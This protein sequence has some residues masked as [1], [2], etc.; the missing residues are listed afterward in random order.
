M[1]NLYLEVARREWN[2]ARRKA[3]WLQL[4]SSLSSK[5]IDLINFD[6]LS[7]H[8]DLGNAAYRGV[9]NIPVAKIMGSVGRYQDFVQAFL[10]TTEN[11]RHRWEKIATLYLDPSSRGLPPIEVYQVGDGYF[12]ADGNHR[13]SVVRQLGLQDIEAHVWEYPQSVAGLA[14]GVD[15]DTLLIEAERRE[16]LAKTH[17]DELRPGHNIR[18]TAPGGYPEMLNQIAHYQQVLS[19]IDET[20]ISYEQAVRA[21]YDMIYKSTVLLI[22]NAGVLDIFPN[23]TAADFFIWAGQH[24][25]ELEEQYGQAVLMEDAVKD[26]RKL[27]RTPVVI[28]SWRSVWGWLKHRL[29]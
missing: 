23:R 21:W 16:F 28:R 11:M 7:Q 15:I 10:P 18:L 9:Q 24:H 22:E 6:Q 4:R 1:E 26:I 19:L 17:L 20:E 12:V 5:K 8:F 2:Q 27:N 25:R 14:P 29:G 3:L 13:V